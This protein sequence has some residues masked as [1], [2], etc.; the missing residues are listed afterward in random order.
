M[1]K[2]VTFQTIFS[3]LFIFLFERL[4]TICD[5][6]IPQERKKKCNNLF[7]MNE[8]NISKSQNTDL[9]TNGLSKV[10]FSWFYS[11]V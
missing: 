8:I 7:N 4:R 6:K 3:N 1:N 5:Y 11:K 2:D 10:Y 9:Q